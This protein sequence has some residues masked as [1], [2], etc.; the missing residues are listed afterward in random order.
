[1]TRCFARMPGIYGVPGLG[2]EADLQ[3]GDHP[4]YSPALDPRLQKLTEL[5]DRVFRIYE[6]RMR[7]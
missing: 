7:G 3:V 6:E 4:L 2:P 1:M 5:A